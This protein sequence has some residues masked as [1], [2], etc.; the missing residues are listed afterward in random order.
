MKDFRKYNSK[1]FDES[2]K[3]STKA[4]MRLSSVETI[5]WYIKCPNNYKFQCV[6]FILTDRG[7]TWWETIERMLGGDE[8]QIT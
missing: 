2:L 5:F 1:I 3:G 7:T 6:I 8:N 4:Q